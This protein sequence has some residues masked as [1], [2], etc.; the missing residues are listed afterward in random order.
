MH[1]ILA[2]SATSS[3]AERRP[4]LR[5]S[6]LHH[7]MIALS[8][9]W[10]TMAVV[11]AEETT[12]RTRDSL[13]GAWYLLAFQCFRLRDGWTDFFP[14]VRGIN[15]VVMSI[16]RRGDNTAW[17]LDKVHVRK[18]RIHEEW[19][20]GR[21][22]RPPRRLISGMMESFRLVEDQRQEHNAQAFLD[23]LIKSAAA[24]DQDD[25]WKGYEAIQSVWELLSNADSVDSKALE[26]CSKPSARVLIA[27]WLA[28]MLLLKPFYDLE[29]VLGRQG[30]VA[31]LPTW[32]F[33]IARV[34]E[35]DSD[36]TGRALQWPVAVASAYASLDSGYDRLDG[37]D[38]P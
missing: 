8:R 9:I 11:D 24:L 26:D 17:G 6:A 33:D 20:E 5:V 34:S 27:H 1:A 10:G 21:V 36:S 15:L 38:R 12:S 7:R 30:I 28:M 25:T 2:C 31:Q 19:R 23:I 35:R 29:V 13:L 14:L 3:T 22:E 37:Q 32:I 16:M 18:E 4:G